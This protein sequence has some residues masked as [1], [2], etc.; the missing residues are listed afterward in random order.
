MAFLIMLKSLILPEFLIKSTDCTL[1]NNFGYAFDILD[2]T[3]SN[4]F[5]MFYNLQK[6]FLDRPVNYFGVL[7]IGQAVIV[8]SIRIVKY[9]SFQRS[10]LKL[11]L[12]LTLIHP[13]PIVPDKHFLNIPA[14]LLEILLNYRN[15]IIL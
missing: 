6:L 5:V 9:E 15:N 7:E 10:I 11:I 4:N 3:S 1:S 8:L 13:I 2:V 14:F 12:Q